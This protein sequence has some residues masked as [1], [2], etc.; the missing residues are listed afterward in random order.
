MARKKIYTPRDIT[1]ELIL[2]WDPETFI[3]NLLYLHRQ[4]VKSLLIWSSVLADGRFGFTND[5]QKKAIE[6][7]FD[8]ANKIENLNRWLRM[9]VDAKQASGEQ[10]SAEE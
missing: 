1:D 10:N 4:H 7:V 8:A 2:S 9:Y 5:D 3:V 6:D